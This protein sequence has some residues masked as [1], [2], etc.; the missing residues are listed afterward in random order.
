MFGLIQKNSHAKYKCVKC[1]REHFAI[2]GRCRAN[3]HNL[4]M[5]V[6]EEKEERRKEETRNAKT[7]RTVNKEEKNDEKKKSSNIGLHASR[8]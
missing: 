5:K 4:Y 1:A 8:L 3:P 2:S 7:Q 6:E